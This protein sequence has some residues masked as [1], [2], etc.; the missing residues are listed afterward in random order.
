MSTIAKAIQAGAE[1]LSLAGISTPRLDAEVL[2]RHVLGV[3]RT[4][5]FVRLRDPLSGEEQAAFD[6]LIE[7]RLAG[8]PIAYMTGKREFM[9]LSFAV[10]PGVLI[11]R[12][13]T[14]VLVEWALEW[15]RDRQPA[16]IVDIGTGSGA[17][18]L[19]I[20][21]HRQAGDQIFGVDLSR[22]AIRYA[23]ANRADLG[24]DDSVHLVLGDLLGWC[25]GPIEL[26]LGNLPYLRPEQV[27]S[28]PDL[29]AE[30]VSA[31]SSGSDG[32]DAIRRLLADVSR[33]MSA[34]GAIALEIDPSQTEAMLKLMGTTLRG[35]RVDVLR[36]LAGWDRV[37]VG[38]L[39]SRE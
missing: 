39:P 9:G 2:L 8:E 36:D 35:A 13:E 19:S 31:L 7:R 4:Q 34:S 1:Q 14:E 25:S 15:L 23:A 21:M 22:A 5:L 10:G 17:I 26:V 38:T 3:D 11:P 12:P 32:L 30:P 37:V 20:A 24:L 33:V 28:N 29:R 18:A 16:T 27:S 6:G